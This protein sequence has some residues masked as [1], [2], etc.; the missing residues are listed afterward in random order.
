[1]AYKLN[2]IDFSTYGIMPGRM[3]GENLAVKGI[4]DL[5]SRI[6][7]THYDWAETNGVEPFVDADEIFLGSR[8]I[9]F[10]G[11]MQG[12]VATLKIL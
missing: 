8:T 2:N 4:F 11:I 6:G 7:D 1:M 5:P 12:N 3:E 10:Q 9:Y